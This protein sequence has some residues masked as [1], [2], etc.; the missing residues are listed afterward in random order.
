M[1]LP[2]DA[3][4]PRLV[5][6]WFNIS[7][8][9]ILLMTTLLRGTVGALG[10]SALLL[11]IAGCGEEA[12]PAAQV[13]GGPGEGL[14]GPGGGPNEPVPAYSEFA[15]KGQTPSIRQIM[16]K[17]T[18][19]R[20]S[21]TEEIGKELEADLPAWETIQGQTKEYVQFAS[22]LG[23]NTPRRGSQESW[24]KQTAAFAELAMKLDQA[25]QAKDADAALDVHAQL[26]NT[27]NSCHRE[28]RMGP[29]GLGGMGPGGRP[30]LGPGGPPGLG[31]GGPPGGPRGGPPGMPP[32]GYPGAPDGGN[33]G[34]P[35]GEKAPAPEPAP[36]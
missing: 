1:I 21:L 13:P 34:P 12:G 28:H 24:E 9:V 5:R 3:L 17:L 32:P 4:R 30:A 15:A 33:A 2:D 29:G 27:C 11:L 16:R 8:G 31:P 22:A 25:A 20:G 7:R 26:K 36:K 14:R 35:S 23:K 10:V 18:A 6:D 19:P